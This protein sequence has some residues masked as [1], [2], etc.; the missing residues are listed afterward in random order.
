MVFKFFFFPLFFLR[1]KKNN[2]N[3][4]TKT[5]KSYNSRTQQI[6]FPIQIVTIKCL[7][8]P[9]RSAHKHVGSLFGFISNLTNFTDIHCRFVLTFLMSNDH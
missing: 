1:T 4:L 8:I 3:S 7:P 9:W 2:Y 5:I 6:L